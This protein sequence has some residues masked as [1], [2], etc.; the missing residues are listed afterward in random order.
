MGKVGN[1]GNLG[2]GGNAGKLCGN[3]G[4]LGK[5]DNAGSRRKHEVEDFHGSH[6]NT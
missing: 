5:E 1:A 4:K 6:S 3:A 2:K